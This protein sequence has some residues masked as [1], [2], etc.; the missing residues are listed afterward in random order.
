MLNLSDDEVR[1]V[2]NGI[3]VQCESKFENH[4]HVRLRDG[5]RLLAVG[6][7][8]ESKRAVHPKVVFAD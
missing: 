1:R 3:D 2:A 5:G 8:D 6:V 7:Y 4:E